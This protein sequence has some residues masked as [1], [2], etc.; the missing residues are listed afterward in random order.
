MKAASLL[1]VAAMAV[2]AALAAAPGPENVYTLSNGTPCPPEGSAKKA[3]VRAINVKKNRFN[4]PT[5][6]DIDTDVTLATM[7]APGEDENRFDDS[8]AARVVGFVMNVKV[9]GRETC[10]CGATNPIDRDTHI[11]LALSP[12]APANQRVIVEVTPRLR[13]QMK[14]RADGAADW[15]TLTLQSHGR[16]G[17]KGKWVEVTGWLLFDFEHT[18]GAENSSPG[19]PGNWRATCWEIHPVTE[20]T[21]LPGAPENNPA[22]APNTLRFMQRAHVLHAQRDKARSAAIAARNKENRARFAEEDP[23]ESKPR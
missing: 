21:V 1:A 5:A 20:I 4:A 12:Q 17:I 22:L 19:N 2:V 9:G 11:E 15:R 8:R 7:L 18:D 3:V 23:K 14:E 13:K 16:G 10:N 6:D